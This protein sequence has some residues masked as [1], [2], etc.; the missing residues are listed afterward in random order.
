M[1]RLTVARLREVL[2]YDQLTGLFTWRISTSNRVAVGATA[3]T[4]HP[5]G[6]IQFSVDHVR[7]LAH[8][9]AIAYVTG[10]W[11][12]DEVDHRDG[13]RTNNRLSNLRRASHTLNAENLRTA[14]ANNRCGFLGVS[15][16]GP[17]Y[18]ATI[19]VNGVRH[20]IGLFE[21][22]EKAHEAYL[23][24]KRRMHEGCTI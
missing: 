14:K 7:C 5:K 12:T 21:T 17:K 10:E 8:R 1:R 9:A 20:R 6:Y 24:A 13:V 22:P 16:H 4:A 23:D 19:H 2:D 15:R 18:R 11:P 3:G